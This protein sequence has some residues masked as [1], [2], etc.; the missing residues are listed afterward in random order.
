[1]TV[2][3]NGCLV[4]IRCSIG[5]YDFFSIFSFDLAL[6]E[7]YIRHSRHCLTTFSNKKYSNTCHIFNSQVGVWKCGETLA[8]RRY[9]GLLHTPFQRE[10]T[11]RWVQRGPRKESTLIWQTAPWLTRYQTASVQNFCIFPFSVTAVMKF[12]TELSNTM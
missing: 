2:T 12:G 5:F 8:C 7:R 1:M 9:H 3:A 10:K 4:L 6:I 11:L